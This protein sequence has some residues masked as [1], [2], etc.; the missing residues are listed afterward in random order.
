[1]KATDIPPC[2][3][4]KVPE[5][6]APFHHRV[7]CQTRFSDFD[8]FRHLNNNSYMSFLDL[9]KAH[10]Y[11]DVMGDVFNFA[12]TTAVIVN[13][14]VS[15][16]SPTYMDEQ[17]AVLTAVVK[18]S[19]HSFIFDQRIVNPDT[20]DVK[21]YATTVMAAFD[22]NSAKGAEIPQEWL[23][24]IADFENWPETPIFANATAR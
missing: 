6:P 12:K 1:M 8:M 10:Y 5:A 21:C 15:F 17:I 18:V 23:K 7:D 13:T 4:P 2:R 14:N 22:A 20:G 11:I 16:C 24:A 3:N 9:G 19:Q